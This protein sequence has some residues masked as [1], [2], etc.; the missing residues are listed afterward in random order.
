MYRR[1]VSCVPNFG[2]LNMLAKI[3][4]SAERGSEGGK[5]GISDEFVVIKHMPRYCE[6][7]Q[8]RRLV[9]V[10]VGHTLWCVPKVF[11]Q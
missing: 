5:R 8:G 3:G 6:A 7:I 10:C 9:S 2:G 11:E 1:T 4:E